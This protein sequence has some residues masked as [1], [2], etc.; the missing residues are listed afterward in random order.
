MSIV[1]KLLNIGAGVAE[2]AGNT[3]KSKSVG[4]AG[5]KSGQFGSTL[6]KLGE[7][8]SSD[9][10]ET[11]PKEDLG[12]KKVKLSRGGLEVEISYP[13]SLLKGKGKSP[14]GQKL[15]DPAILHEI[16]GKGIPVKGKSDKKTKDSP[17][18]KN[19][20]G[21]VADQKPGTLESL[22]VSGKQKEI[23]S[24][25]KG[26]EEK[27]TTAQ[28]TSE[29]N[30]KKVPVVDKQ[31]SGGESTGKSILKNQNSTDTKGSSEPQKTISSDSKD[32]KKVADAAQ[33]TSMAASVLHD[34]V[35]GGSDEHVKKPSAEVKTDIPKSSGSI[36]SKKAG[37]ASQTN[38]SNLSN[39][40]RISGSANDNKPL[41]VNDKGIDAT[42][43]TTG[44]GKIYASDIHSAKKEQT[45]IPINKE[46]S[47]VAGDHLKISQD[48]P[49]V[50]R[51]RYYGQRV[52]KTS[53]QANDG[54]KDKVEIKNSSKADSHNTHSLS[55]DGQT[56]TIDSKSINSPLSANGG[57]Q[58]SGGDQHGQT[59]SQQV[60]N[61]KVKS[62]D[63]VP[64]M[65][66]DSS[67]NSVSH[68]HVAQ[69]TNNATPTAAP[70]QANVPRIVA[71]RLVSMVQKTPQSAQEQQIWQKHRLVM[72]NGQTLNVSA[73]TTDG[74]LHLQLSG[75]NQDL[76]KLL[77]QHMQEIQTHLQEKMHVQVDLQF[78]NQSNGQP[79][80]Q[81]QQQSGN[82]GTY[83]Q[84]RKMMNNNFDERT[85]EPVERP[86]SNRRLGYN[87]TEWTA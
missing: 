15:N 52:V 29:K 21:T 41:S 87:N 70:A 69:S 60:S 11:N 32:K 59:P 39:N 23:T 61:P 12:L 86:L 22:K 37:H 81:F 2:K 38:S 26:K 57:K 56:G 82:R 10:K 62:E 55:P 80:Q 7:D 66:V 64:K 27:S 67:N 4:K 44:K 77:Q 6:A 3:G 14:I 71:E 34:A 1:E 5:E 48:A 36:D 75:G 47:K 33:T 45:A 63:P 28:S 54:P 79:A 58:H 16:G 42:S 43:L 24:I 50:V 17:S 20:E 49:S 53:P 9:G 68:A 18:A 74:V 30:L 51:D 8:V 73:K 19:A 13:K 84:P 31:V 25:T 76:N 40:P 72:D 65:P 83:G 35:S 78:Q 85:A 46:T